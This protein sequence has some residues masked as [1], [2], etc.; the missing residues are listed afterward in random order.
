[1]TSREEL[2][3]RYSP[4]IGEPSWLIGQPRREQFD[5]LRAYYEAFKWFQAGIDS[6]MKRA[7]IVKGQRP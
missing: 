3:D 2:I 1:M 6:E 4:D 7:E 5:N